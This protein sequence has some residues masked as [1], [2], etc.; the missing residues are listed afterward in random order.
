MC[1][2][3]LHKGTRPSFMD[4]S[5]K[6][7]SSRNKRPSSDH[8]Q[9]N[10]YSR[11]QQPPVPQPPVPRHRKASGEPG[12][13]SQSPGASALSCSHGF[14]AT[15]W[16]VVGRRNTRPLPGLRPTGGTQGTTSKVGAT[17]SVSERLCE[18]PLPT[19]EGTGSAHL[20]A[21]PTRWLRGTEAR[22]QASPAGR[23]QLAK[24]RLDHGHSH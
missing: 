3:V 19:F 14:I 7:P 20:E 15:A 12:P 17:W 18:A 11:A 22:A 13:V 10:G 2:W 21:P 5:H 24:A 1:P 9:G 23:S 4:L 6:L 16:G 8:G